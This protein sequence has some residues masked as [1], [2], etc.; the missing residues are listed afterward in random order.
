MGQNLFVDLHQDPSGDPWYKL[1]AVGTRLSV[2][3]KIY[4][5]G[6][7]IC[8]CNGA[9]LNAGNLLLRED[10]LCTTLRSSSLLVALGSMQE[11]APTPAYR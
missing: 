11:H 7:S 9:C 1:R 2:M 8:T 6:H 4:F 5:S 3:S 10:A